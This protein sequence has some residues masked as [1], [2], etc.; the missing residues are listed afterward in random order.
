VGWLC[1]RKAQ[2]KSDRK[3]LR[4]FDGEPVTPAR[5]KREK[6]RLEALGH[7]ESALQTI[8]RHGVVPRL[9][10][11]QQAS[12][13]ISVSPSTLDGWAKQRRIPTIRVSR[14]RKFDRQDLDRFI[15]SHRQEAIDELAL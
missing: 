9:L 13:Y 3:V 11:L 7:L 14:L 1:K 10:D 5:I 12:A 15:E 2:L 4:L 8:A 6:R